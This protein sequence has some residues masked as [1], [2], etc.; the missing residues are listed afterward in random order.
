MDEQHNVLFAGGI[1]GSIFVNL[2]AFKDA[3]IPVEEEDFGDNNFLWRAQQR[4]CCNIPLFFS[5]R[6]AF[7]ALVR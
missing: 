3:M 7:M 6:T 1:N 5:E 4:D 2:Q